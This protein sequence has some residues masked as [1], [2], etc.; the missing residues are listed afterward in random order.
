[1]SRRPVQQRVLGLL[2]LAVAAA[3]SGCAGYQIGNREL[4]RPDIQ[5][6]YVPVFQSESLRRGMGERLT[7]AVIKEIELRTPYKVSSSPDADSTLTGRI[8]RETKQVL[9]QNQ[10]SDARLYASEF[11]V[12]TRWLN[13]RGE[14][15]TQR[16]VIPLPQLAVEEQG[17]TTYIPEA[18]Q[19]LATAQQQA[20]QRLAEQIVGQME[21]WW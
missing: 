10:N 14:P 2:T 6:V 20:L 4:F 8:V 19:S 13:R 16:S 5:T 11:T 12:E 1:M 3:L 7:E 17:L 21:V 9:A 15:L 18:G